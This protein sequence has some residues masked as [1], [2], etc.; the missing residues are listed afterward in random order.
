MYAAPVTEPFFRLFRFF[1]DIIPPVVLL[2]QLHSFACYTIYPIIPLL[3]L[4]HSS[5]CHTSQSCPTPNLVPLL[6]LYHRRCNALHRIPLLLLY[7]ILPPPL[8]SCTTYSVVPHLIVYTSSCC[9]IHSLVPQLPVVP[10]FHLYSAACCTTLV[11]LLLCVSCLSW[12]TTNLVTRPPLLSCSLSLVLKAPVIHH[13]SKRMRDHKYC[14]RGSPW[15]LPKPLITFW[16]FTKLPI[17]DYGHDGFWY[18]GVNNVFL[19]QRSKA[20]V[21]LNI[22]DCLLIHDKRGQPTNKESQPYYFIRNRLCAWPISWSVSHTSTFSRPMSKMTFKATHTDLAL[23]QKRQQISR[24]RRGK[25][26]SV[27]NSNLEAIFYSG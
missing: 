27:W 19:P 3:T 6:I 20:D 5:P 26:R 18:Q 4:Y 1:C 21:Q 14:N 2:L 22:T 16:L 9:T 8:N 12:A 24:L 11:A 10:P 7:N 23:V 17:N 15:I 13:D 25:V